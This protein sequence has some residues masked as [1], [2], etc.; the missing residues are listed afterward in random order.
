MKKLLK[1]TAVLGMLSMLMSCGR[2]VQITGQNNLD[3]S[4]EESALTTGEVLTTEE[5]TQPTREKAPQRVKINTVMPESYELSDSCIIDGFTTVMQEPELPTGC[6]I[7][8]LDQTMQYYG[9]MIDKVELCDVFMPV[10]YDGYYTMDEVYLGDPHSSNGFGC[11][12]TV[13]EKTANDYF[14]CIGSDWYATDLTGISLS[15]VFYQIEQGRPVIVW[16]TIDQIESGLSYVFTLGCGEDFYFNYYQ[17]CLTVYGFD[18]NEGVVY[19]ADPLAGN[20]TYDISRFERIFNNMGNQAVIL[21]GNESSAGRIYS[22]IDEQE[23]WLAVNRPKDDED[24]E[25]ENSSEE[26]SDLYEVEG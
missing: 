25:D 21:A 4:G 13:I 5:P 10:D 12:A 14:E 2:V 8:S 26:S 16:S 20:V 18:Y 11:N 17:H 23:Q 3:N 6:E 9:F 19:V 1:F 22:S 7:T 24:D 15:E